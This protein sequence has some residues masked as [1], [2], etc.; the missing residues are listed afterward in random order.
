MDL[1]SVLIE[2]RRS[3]SGMSS[4]PTS[5]LRFRLT[6]QCERPVHV[7]YTT[8]NPWATYIMEPDIGNSTS[9]LDVGTVYVP[10]P[11]WSRWFG[12]GNQPLPKRSRVLLGPGGCAVMVFQAA[13][14]VHLDLTI[15]R[16]ADRF[17]AAFRIPAATQPDDCEARH[18]VSDIQDGEATVRLSVWPPLQGIEASL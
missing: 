10:L 9:T 5:V 18:V 17:E 12:F 13:F 4:K 7:S 14:S 3:S 16:T 2:L 11:W 1:G 15:G 6:N 8:S